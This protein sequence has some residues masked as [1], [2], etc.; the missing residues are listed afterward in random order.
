MF[1]HFTK[2]VL[3]SCTVQT[4]LSVYARIT[5]YDTAYLEHKN[6]YSI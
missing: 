6:C 5:Y 4:G 3:L 2:F 1:L